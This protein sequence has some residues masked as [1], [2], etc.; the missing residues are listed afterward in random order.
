VDIDFIHSFPASW[1][2]ESILGE[3]GLWARGSFLRKAPKA[4][5]NQAQLGG[6]KSLETENGQS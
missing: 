1:E 6:G 2:Y 4:R 5:L 3:D